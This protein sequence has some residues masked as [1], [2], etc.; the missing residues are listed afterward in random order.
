LLSPIIEIKSW[1]NILTEE[2][3]KSLPREIYQKYI[4]DWYFYA[5]KD[6]IIVKGKYLEK[7][8]FRKNRAYDVDLVIRIFNKMKHAGERLSNLVEEYN[9][10]LNSLRIKFYI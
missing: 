10:D 6:S 2:E 4:K 8:Y 9:K 1:K 7:Y 5:E 3:L